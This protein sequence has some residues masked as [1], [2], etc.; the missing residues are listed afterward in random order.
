M[1]F[2]GK[3]GRRLKEIADLEYFR[4]VCFC[5]LYC[6]RTSFI[7]FA[8]PRVIGFK[9]QS[10]F[11][12]ITSCNIHRENL[13][14][15]DRSTLDSDRNYQKSHSKYQQSVCANSETMALH[16]IEWK[17]FIVG[18]KPYS[19]FQRRDFDVNWIHCFRILPC[20]DHQ[21]IS[22]ISKNSKSARKSLCYVRV[23]TR[24]W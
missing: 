19:V 21:E 3:F 4:D 22:P 13:A 16:E 11:C 18:R 2:G 15:A 23:R 12:N 24:W 6:K 5:L 1:F 10:D 17:I 7:L 8:L 9:P 14:E 20:L